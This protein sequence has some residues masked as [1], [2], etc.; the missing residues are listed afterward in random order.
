MGHEER[1]GRESRE[2]MQA[3]AEVEQARV[4]SL[5]FEP[6]GEAAGLAPSPFL[7]AVAH[8]RLAQ[9]NAAALGIRGFLSRPNLTIAGRPQMDPVATLLA[10][11]ALLLDAQAVTMDLLLS[12]LAG[13]PGLRPVA[14][15]ANGDEPEVPS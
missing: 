5:P 2:A 9:C 1:F 4:Q 10:N 14:P 3:L 13:K 11:V 12:F 15:P 7:V 6:K 8:Q